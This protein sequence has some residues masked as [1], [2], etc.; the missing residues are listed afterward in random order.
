[1]PSLFMSGGKCIA[2]RKQGQ[3]WVLQAKEEQNF[4]TAPFGFAYPNLTTLRHSE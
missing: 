2:D 4:M 1:M 3:N